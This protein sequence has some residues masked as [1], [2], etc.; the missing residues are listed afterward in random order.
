MWRG[1][2]TG[3]HKYFNSMAYQGAEEDWHKHPAYNFL[4]DNEALVCKEH[5]KEGMID[6]H[7]KR[8]AIEG[9]I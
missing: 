9:C 6:I 2:Q 4:C 3:R 8:C 5:A 7:A 1:W